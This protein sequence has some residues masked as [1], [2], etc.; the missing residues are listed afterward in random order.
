MAVTINTQAPAAP[1][2]TL[3]PADDT[4]APTHP[5]V[6]NVRRPPLQ[7]HRH[8]RPGDR[9]PLG[10]RRPTTPRAS[11]SPRRPSP[12]TGPTW[13]RSPARWPTAP[14]RWWPG[15]S[16][17]RAT[18]ATAPPLTVTIKATGPQIVPTL[19]ILAGRRH[20][21]SRGT[22]S[23]PT[24]GPGSSARPTRATPS[25][26]TPSINGQLSGPQATDHLLDDQRVVPAPAPL[27]PDRRQH[28]AGGPGH[29]HRRQQG[30]AQPGP[31]PSGSS[32]SP[33][34]TST[35]GPPSSPSSAR[36]PR[37]TTSGTSGSS[38]STPP[39]AATSRSSTT[40]TATA[41]S[42][43]S[44]TASTPP[45]TS[46]PSPTAR[47]STSSSA[48]AASR[49]RSPATTTARARFDLRPLQPRHR[50]LGHQP[51][52][53]PAARSSASACPRST[54]RPRRPTTA[55][56]STEI[57]VF[58]P[59]VVNGNDADSFNVVAAELLQQLP[60]QLH[61]PGGPGPGLHLQGRR[62]PRPGRLRRGR[63]RRVRHLPADAPASSSSSTCPTSST[64]PPG[65]SG[66]SR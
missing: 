13:P 54:S 37:P 39:P 26:S 22:A 65:P 25:R 56:A 29:R 45:S 3:F 21:R 9:H 48:P 66:R 40:S 59:S 6:T 19:S 31:E 57:A 49:C 28:P 46:G 10:H 61:R 7:R 23:P 51:A 60:G 34:T 17:R 36:P 63:P 1:T 24:A 4:G 2:L 52:H 41:R 30:A 15:P 43:R 18:S 55:T 8:A 16:T 53:G 38:R 32:P 35:P 42:T 11:R 62:H 50:D 58:R 12:P 20:R 14:T 5:D 44:P 47:P 27:Q 64:R 33:A